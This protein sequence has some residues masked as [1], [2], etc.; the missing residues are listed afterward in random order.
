MEKLIVSYCKVGDGRISG[1][2]VLMGGYSN[3]QVARL[4]ARNYFMKGGWIRLRDRE[5]CLGG[6]EDSEN[7]DAIVGE[8]G[9]NRCH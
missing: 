6:D 7:C 1:N 2:D 8:Q 3:K 4:S 9:D 5:L